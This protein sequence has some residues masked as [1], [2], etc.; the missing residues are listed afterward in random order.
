M[1][2][3]G[4]HRP[5]FLFLRPCPVVVSPS[6]RTERHQ[7]TLSASSRER[8]LE[9]G[10]C[11][12]QLLLKRKKQTPDPASTPLLPSKSRLINA[13]TLFFV[14]LAGSRPATRSEPVSTTPTWRTRDWRTGTRAAPTPGCSGIQSRRTNSKSPRPRVMIDSAC[15]VR[16]PARRESAVE[17]AT[18]STT[19][20]SHSSR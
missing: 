10:R 1:S 2:I 7:M 8:W 16:I 19:P 6:D 18:K 12:F 14:I 17:S 4:R 3:T 5:P 20:P 13:G 15:R 11:R 9:C